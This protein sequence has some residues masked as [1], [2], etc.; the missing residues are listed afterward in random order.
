[1]FAHGLPPSPFNC[2]FIFSNINTYKKTLG[3]FL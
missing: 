1:M 3:V 2:I